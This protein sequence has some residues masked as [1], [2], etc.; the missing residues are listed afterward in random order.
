SS[1]S[2]AGGRYFFEMA[3]VPPTV[4]LYAPDGKPLMR[5]FNVLKNGGRDKISN[6][7]FSGGLKATI[8]PLPGWEIVGN[9]NI[10]GNFN[11]GKLHKKM[12][13]DYLID[14]SKRPIAGTFPTDFNKHNN[15]SNYQSINIYTSY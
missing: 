8:N 12:V 9:Y 4:A 1:S 7:Q 13:S 15:Q 14:G 6:N 10:R 2:D 5:L 3:R 11:S